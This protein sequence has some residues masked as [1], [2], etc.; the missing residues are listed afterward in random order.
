MPGSLRMI[1]VLLLAATAM[2]LPGALALPAAPPVHIHLHPAG[3]HSSKPTAPAVPDPAPTSYQ[4]CVNGHHAAVPNGL[5]TL[6]SMA[7]QLCSLAAA[8]QLRLSSASYRHSTIS[9]VPSN[10]PPGAAPLRI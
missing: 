5:F 9:V 10:S 2:S 1:A 7:A 3:C 6:R 8:E 4:C